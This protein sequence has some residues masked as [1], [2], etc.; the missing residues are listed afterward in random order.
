MKGYVGLYLTNPHVNYL[1]TPT[2]NK[3]RKS[4]NNIL[5]TPV[6]CFSTHIYK[7]NIIYCH[8]RNRGG[9]RNNNMM[10][11]PLMNPFPAKKLIESIL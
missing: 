3:S 4:Y 9:S 6:L 2:K 5:L 11:N 1:V 8:E 10:Q 7:I